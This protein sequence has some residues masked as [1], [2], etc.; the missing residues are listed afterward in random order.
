MWLY[1]V[2]FCFLSEATCAWNGNDN[3]NVNIQVGRYGSDIY[4]C[5]Y[6]RVCIWLMACFCMIYRYCVICV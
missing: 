4:M 2:L 6:V 3:V 5:M 1:N